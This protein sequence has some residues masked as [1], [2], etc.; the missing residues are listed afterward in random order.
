MNSRIQYKILFSLVARFVQTLPCDQD[1]FRML[2]AIAR[3]VFKDESRA[4]QLDASIR[5]YY[6]KQQPHQQGIFS[7]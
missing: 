5:S 7:Y 3:K 4:A 2:P 1:V 6:T